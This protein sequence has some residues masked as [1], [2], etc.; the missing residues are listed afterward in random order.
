MINGVI[1]T[2]IGVMNRKVKLFISCAA[3]ASQTACGESF[4]EA[5]CERVTIS[6][7][8]KPIIGIEDMAYDAQGQTL[9]LSAYDRRTHDEGGI[10]RLPIENSASDLTLKPVIEGLRPH[11][12]NLTRL[13]NTV[14][15]SVIDRQGDKADKKPVIRFWS[16][17]IETSDNMNELK[18]LS[19]PEI[20]AANDLILGAGEFLYI[21]QDHKKCTS[22]AQKRE[23]I[24]SPHQ[25]KVLVYRRLGGKLDLIDPPLLSGL[26]FANGIT[27][28]QQEG[29]L[30]VAETRKKQLTLFSEEK[31]ERTTIR[32]AGGPDNLTHD[33]T[34]VY[35]ALIPSLIRFSRFQKND[36][37]R[38][39]SRF[40]VISPD[41]DVAT[42]DVPSDVISGATVAIKAGD[43]I[44]LGAAYDTAIARC[45]LGISS[46]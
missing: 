11:G 16:W 3:F 35:A 45:S 37:K 10:Y 23:N 4:P 24:F 33:G 32:L 2:R 30:Y 20:C 22:K 19:A 34:H 31:V 5:N 38:I 17:H 36:S 43:H 12:I 18:S 44:W 25:A 29:L 21:T 13:D 7:D 42:Y 1:S 9:Y 8:G 46:S 27:K 15:L 26:S 28:S 40:A 14:Y 39:K 41:N 6:H